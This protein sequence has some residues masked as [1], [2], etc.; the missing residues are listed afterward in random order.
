M[1]DPFPIVLA[2]LAG[3][4]IGAGMI[5]WLDTDARRPDPAPELDW[6]R[7]YPG[8]DRCV[9]LRYRATPAILTTHQDRAHGR[10]LRQGP[11]AW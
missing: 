8:C 7:P 10:V 1:T 2:F 11:S 4:F 6:P 3:I 5:L 9:S